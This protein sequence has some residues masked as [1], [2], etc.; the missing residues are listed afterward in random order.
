MDSLTISRVDRLDDY[1]K[2]IGKQF[3]LN[4]SFSD[5]QKEYVP[6]KFNF[7]SNIIENDNLEKAGN[8]AGREI[9]E[10]FLKI[11]YAFSALMP[12]KVEII[13]DAE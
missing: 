5:S 10:R 4:F 8:E 3:Q 13:N 2:F 7:L 9:V 12:D 1:N 6:E 11:Y